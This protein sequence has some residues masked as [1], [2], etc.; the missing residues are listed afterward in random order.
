[1]TIRLAS[2]PM[3]S[4]GLRVAAPMHSIP[5]LPASRAERKGRRIS[6]QPMAESHA[7]AQ[8]DEVSNIQKE[9][10]QMLAI[11]ESPTNLALPAFARLAGKSRDQIN[12]EIKAARLLSLSLGNRGQRIPDWQLESLKLR[13]V[14][15]VIGRAPEIGSWEIYRMLSEPHK[16]LRGSSPVHAVSCENFDNILNCLIGGAERAARDSTAAGR[17]AR[18]TSACAAAWRC[19]LPMAC[20]QSELE[21]HGVGMRLFFMLACQSDRFLSPSSLA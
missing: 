4:D 20:A 3:Q 9:R 12:R 1:M 14:L 19:P 6:W 8:S 2:Q 11:Y 15:P 5:A 10:A 17:S 7:H 18:M 16:K 21:P 13:V